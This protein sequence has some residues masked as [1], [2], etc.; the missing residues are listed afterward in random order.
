MTIFLAHFFQ[1]IECHKHPETIYEDPHAILA[2][3]VDFMGAFF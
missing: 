1:I 2:I 3:T